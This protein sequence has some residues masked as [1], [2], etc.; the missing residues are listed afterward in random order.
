MKTWKALLY[1]LSVAAVSVG[2]LTLLRGLPTREQLL[3]NGLTMFFAAFVLMKYYV[4]GK[5]KDYI[6]I[7][8]KWKKLNE[9]GRCGK[10]ENEFTEANP[11]GGSGMCRNCWAKIH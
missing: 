5:E 3:E 6:I 7:D 9:E 10:C 2:L 11:D 1:A 4:G 8:D